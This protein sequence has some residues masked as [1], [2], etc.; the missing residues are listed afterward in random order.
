MIRTVLLRLGLVGP[1]TA[2]ERADQ[3]MRRRTR[4]A[5][6]IAAE[7]RPEHGINAEAMAA[8]VILLDALVDRGC[9]RASRYVLEGKTVEAG[10]ALAI[11]DMAA[12]IRTDHGYEMAKQFRGRMQEMPVILLLTP[13][14]H[15]YLPKRIAEREVKIRADLAYV[16]RLTRG[17]RTGRR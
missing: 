4:Q 12:E 13:E 8:G 6:R 16:E 1:R 9:K 2:A 10:R 11:Q 5:A 14:A 3:A 15:E 7:L 17:G